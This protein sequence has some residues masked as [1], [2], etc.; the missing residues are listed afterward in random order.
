MKKRVSEVILSQ[1]SHV[2]ILVNTKV[3]LFHA[4]LEGCVSITESSS[5]HSP[6]PAQDDS[7]VVSLSSDWSYWKSDALWAPDSSTSSWSCNWNEGEAHSFVL[8]EM[9]QTNFSLLLCHLP[10]GFEHDYKMYFH[11]Q[12]SQLCTVKMSGCMIK[13]GGLWRWWRSLIRET[14]S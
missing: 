5:T 8:T 3:V 14:P 2:L 9:T 7:E 1:A 13:R 6:A 12:T 11:R 4:R 10:P